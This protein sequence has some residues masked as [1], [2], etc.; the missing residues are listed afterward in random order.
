MRTKICGG[1]G[2]DQPN[3]EL[4]RIGSFYLCPACVQRVTNHGDYNLEKSV[5]NMTDAEIRAGLRAA[6]VFVPRVEPL[7]DIRSARKLA[8][9]S[10]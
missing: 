3:G 7:Q 5:A 4:I 1:C 6:P 9:G 2:S 10:D 8:F